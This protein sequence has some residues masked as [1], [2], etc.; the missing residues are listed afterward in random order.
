MVKTLRGSSGSV[1]VSGYWSA[2]IVQ[3]GMLGSLR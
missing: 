3:E 2:I 1:F